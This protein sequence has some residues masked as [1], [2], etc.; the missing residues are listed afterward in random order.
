MSFETFIL[1]MMTLYVVSIIPG[2]SMLLALTHGM[3]YGARASLATAAGNTVASAIQASISVVGL[4]VI[5]ATSAPIFMA[6]KILGALYLVY[7]GIKLWR[8]PNWNVS[9]ESVLP[10]QR[11]PCLKLFNQ[12][13]LVAIGNPK[14][15]VF[16]SALFPQ[17][18]NP[19]LTSFSYYLTMVALTAS[20]AFV[21]VMVYAVGGQ[22]VAGFFKKRNFAKAFNKI[23]GGLFVGGGIAIALSE[24]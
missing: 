5:I 14:A 4:G 22:Q 2:P 13:F 16:F 8:A 12:G 9:G 21:C 1:F 17:F 24:R 7:L 18:I 20:C 3:R 10:S 19:E 11:T 23:T 15:I 6:I